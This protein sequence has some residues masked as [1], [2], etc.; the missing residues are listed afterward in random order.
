M[1]ARDSAE[2][3]VIAG[4]PARTLVDARALDDLLDAGADADPLELLEAATRTVTHLLGDKGSCILLDDHPRVLFA[5]HAPT[6]R[7]RPIDLARYPEILAAVASRDIVVIDDVHGDA[8][9]ASVREHL[10]GDLRAI[11]VVP[12]VVRERCLGV[13]LVQS[14]HPRVLDATARATAVLVAHVAAVIVTRLRGSGAV[15]APSLDL[16]STPLAAF[17]SPT[18]EPPGR[19]LVVEDDPATSAAISDALTA[20]GYHVVCVADGAD[21]LKRAF[22]EAPDL[23]LLD[24]NLPGLDGFDTATCLRRST[25]TRAV[26]IVF[27]SGVDDLAVRVREVRLD[28]VDFIPKPFSLDEL[29]ARI[30]LSLGQDRTRRTLRREAE[31]DELTGLGNLR[32]LE[33][34]LAAERARFARYGHALSVA[35]IDVDKLKTIN[36]ERGHLAGSNALRTIARALAA[37][38]RD[39]DLVVRYGGDEFVVLLPHT[40]LADAR[41]FGRR[42]ALAVAALRAEGL[43][44]TVSIG[45]AALTNRGSRETAHDLLRRA[46]A[47]AYRAKQAGGNRV[48]VADDEPGLGE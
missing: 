41:I 29:L 21:G 13:I 37:E 43:P 1:N 33:R 18:V 16:P 35:M 28:P 8:Q 3:S 27:L 23:V 25:R 10:P 19:I 44:L 45:L 32:L 30:Q 7:E 48:C 5:A 46:D 39:T 6:V 12:L 22:E 26:P 9:L 36:D 4:E 34:R 15:V 17:T 40:A 38:A 11:V 42:A 31:H 20:E 47:A 24:V 14:A 2:R